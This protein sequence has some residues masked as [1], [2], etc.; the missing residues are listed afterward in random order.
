MS[1]AELEKLQEL[2]SAF[3]A[4]CGPTR[5]DGRHCDHCKNP[6]GLPHMSFCRYANTKQ[7][8]ES[9]VF[10]EQQA[11]GPSSK[12]DKENEMKE[13]TDRDRAIQKARHYAEQ[14]PLFLDTETTGLR[15][16]VCELAIID[17][18]GQVLINTLIKPT[19]PIPPDAADLHGITNEMVS[20]SPTFKDLLPVLDPLLRGR[21]VLVYNVEFDQNILW[22]SLIANQIWL[23]GEQPFEP[24][25][26]PYVIEPG[27]VKTNWHD[28]MELYA[29]FYGD[30][31]NY[32]GNYRWQRL[33]H[34]A[35]QCNIQLPDILHRAHADAELTR[36]ILLHMAKQ[37]TVTETKEGESDGKPES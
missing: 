2:L 9:F 33:S 3:L 26:N 1:P 24:W 5:K 35:Q 13:Q 19:K 17:L 25:W 8:L 7:A 29:A 23:E 21:T 6:P 14:N 20:E 12:P 30:W 32:H 36:Q 16:E 15:G 37:E 4:V 28:V 22:N 18:Q 11:E 34:A 10:G 27:K 31:N